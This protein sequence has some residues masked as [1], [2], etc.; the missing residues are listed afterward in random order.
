MIVVCT[1]AA[2]KE[3]VLLA[4]SC[5]AFASLL[6]ADLELV[7]RSRRLTITITITITITGVS[8]CLDDVEDFYDNGGPLCLV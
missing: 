2:P 4:L 3:D 8:H 7:L 1:R 5:Q 6:L